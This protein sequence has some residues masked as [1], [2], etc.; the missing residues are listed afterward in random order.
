MRGASEKYR[1]SSGSPSP[2]QV[3]D[4]KA[5]EIPAR[6]RHCDSRLRKRDGQPDR[7][8]E[9]ISECLRSTDDG[10][11]RMLNQ[12]SPQRGT[13]R[14]ALALVA[15]L[16]PTAAP[17]QDERREMEALIVSALRIP[18][19][20]SSVTSAVTVLD[21]KGMEDQGIYELRNALNSV[22]GVV[23]T[24]TGGQTGAVGTLFIRGAGTAY[25]QVVMDGMRLSDSTAPLGN[26][27]AGSRVNDVGTIELLRGP[28]GAIHG[29]ESIGGVL[30]ME[31]PRGAGKPRGSTR[32]EAGAFHSFST[33]SAYE[34]QSGDCSYYLS[35]GYEET[36]NDG[37]DENFHQ[38]N[39]ALRVE[40][41]LDP[42]W[43]LGTTF[44]AVDSFYNDHGSS[45]NRVDSS[46]GT[47]YGIGE[48]SS[49]WTARIH[50]GY[51]QE[52]YDNDS[53]FGN[54]GTDMRA[55][56]LSTDHEVTLAE[57]LRLLAGAY[58]HQSA[59]QNTIGTDTSRDRHGLHSALEWDM[60]D[61]LTVTSALRLDDYDAYGDELT[62]RAGS[63]YILRGTGSTLRGS[64]GTSFRSPSYLDL[65]GSSFGNGN[66][67]LQAE[68]S[69]G[70]DFGI[71]QKIMRHHSLEVAWFE[72][73]ITDRIQSFPTPPV[74]LPGE[75]NTSGLELG[76]RGDFPASSVGYRLAWTYLREGL[77]GAP[78]HA[79]TASVDWEPTEKSLIGIGATHLSDHSW[80]GDPL[81][82]YTVFR[83]YGSYQVSDRFKLHAR[84]ENA[85]NEDYQLSN[86]YGNTVQGAGTGFYTGLSIAW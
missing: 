78:K 44:R 15:L 27:L 57:R 18:R 77:S 52:F 66:P 21:P 31:T 1:L 58:F 11:K 55:G 80:G 51:Q 69:V 73:E 83:I 41:K 82:A 20:A 10:A 54:Y 9:E 75:S 24:S 74:N 23:S 19:E 49:H 37:P 14:S 42:V 56:S 76:L 25:S 79:N 50:A 30:W 72:N 26:F 60:V 33:H 63:V 85:W 29:G 13:C 32:V 5:G 81:A 8:P 64:V 39:A 65:F 62:W 35:A 86:F 48:I 17:A 4:G 67:N 61:D 6:Y 70:W 40:S 28:Q 3:I 7:Q 38:G 46:L 16:F 34:G 36:D 22:P 53:S 12:K 47:L 68:S 71:E 43:T 84:L 59:F 45:E 2:G